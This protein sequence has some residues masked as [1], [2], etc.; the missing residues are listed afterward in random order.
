MSVPNYKGDA[1]FQKI[2]SEMEFDKDV[3]SIKAFVAGYVW[4][5]EM[6]PP[7]HVIEELLLKDTEDEVQMKD[8]KQA[9]SF[10]GSLMGLWNEIASQNK[11]VIYKFRPMPS[12]ADDQKVQK[13]FFEALNWDVNMFLFGLAETESLHCEDQKIKSLAAELEELC[14][15][16]EELEPL[17]K[18]SR[19][20]EFEWDHFFKVLNECDQMWQTLFL[21]MGKSL[22]SYRK[23]LISQSYDESDE[24]RDSPKV[25]RNEPCPCGSGKKYKKCCLPSDIH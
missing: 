25:G 2:L 18:K 7:S 14:D 16:L 5:L 3:Y 23:Q 6:V 17:I 24:I 8:E 20:T 13:A 15:R 10:Y 11:D 9:M 1:A 4:G 22:D 19:P 21:S 12:A